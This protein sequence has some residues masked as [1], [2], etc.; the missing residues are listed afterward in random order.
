MEFA[1]K[2][3]GVYVYNLCCW[4]FLKTRVT[5]HGV[6]PRCD[7]R[8]GLLLVLSVLVKCASQ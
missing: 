2:R 3:G 5:V 1:D 4:D 6:R 7:T 8:K